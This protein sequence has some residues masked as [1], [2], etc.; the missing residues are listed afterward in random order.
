MVVA[1]LA[2]GVA[3][4]GTAIAAGVNVPRF[5]VGPAQLRANAVITP[6]IRNGAVTTPKLRN[7]AVTSLKVRNGSLLAV[8]FAAGQLPAGTAGPAGPPGP[9][10]PSDAYSRFL[11]GPIAVPAASTTLANLNIP[12]AGKYVVW[13]KAYF[14]LAA[15]AAVVTCRLE[16]GTDVDQ[17]QTYVQGNFPFTL[18]TN[19]VH[20][21]AAA[22]SVDFKCATSAG[23]P[24]ANWIKITAIRVANLTNSG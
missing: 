1:C 8:D 10:G 14:T 18:A 15:G 6:K 7:N 23:S 9:A 22:G 17:S 3:L 16:A 13:G 21:F 12:Q 5:S 4:S 20:E 19:V 11:N 2:L 24:Q